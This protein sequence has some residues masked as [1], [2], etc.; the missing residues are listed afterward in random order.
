VTLRA[1]I[2]A[3][4]L[5]LTGCSV[6]T[7]EPATQVTDT[8]AILNGRVFSTETGVDVQ[9]WFRYGTTTAYD[10]QTPERSLHVPADDST[11]L[12]V[13]EPLTGLAPWTTYH[14]QL[15][16]A[17]P[18]GGCPAGDQAFTTG[19]AIA[20]VSDRAAPVA[21][22]GAVW[23]MDAGGHNP[24]RLSPARVGDVR[25]VA[26]SRDGTKLASSTLR[27]IWVMNADGSD[28]HAVVSGS[29]LVDHPT[30]SPDG[31][32]I[33]YTDSR[34]GNGDIYLMD[35]DGTD[36]VRLT[37]GTGTVEE[38][39]SWSPD[40]SRIAFS[41]YD[42]S[43]FLSR[44]YTIGVDGTGLTRLSDSAAFDLSPAWSPDGSKIAFHT[45]PNDI[46][47]MNADGSQRVDLTPTTGADEFSP[48][49]SPDGSRIA[50]VRIPDGSANR[51]VW[52]MKADGTD[53]TQLT[54]GPEVDLSPS[55][56]AAP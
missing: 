22:T 46:W 24:R 23:R 18:R 49:F 9:F 41:D 52:V 3:I 12:P 37:S 6:G 33:A 36:Q 55:W 45:S 51:D 26:A 43:T 13:A 42:P 17:P 8:G 31:S 34:T 10:R 28:A 56:L 2:A 44:I 38:A 1:A 54:R 29:S 20:F 7:S 5:L 32:R 53:A 15:C 30:W 39:A 19:P 16:T 11:P 35:A 27:E 25:N 14:Y 50:F 48:V 47:V 40:G 4:A 21:E